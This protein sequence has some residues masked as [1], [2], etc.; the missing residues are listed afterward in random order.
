MCVGGHAVAFRTPAFNLTCNI[1][2]GSGVNYPPLYWV[3]GTPRISGQACALSHGRLSSRVSSQGGNFLQVPVTIMQ[4]LLPK[5]TDV[6]GVESNIA[7]GLDQVECPVGSG[8]FYCV[9]SVDD[10]GKG[11]AN[12]YRLA[13]MMAIVESWHPPYS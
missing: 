7:Y 4:L 13:F 8:R 2:D 5:G 12:E 1:Y 3:G 9:T 10:V 11:Y 6:R